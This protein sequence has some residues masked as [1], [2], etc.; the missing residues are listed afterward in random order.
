MLAPTGA[1]V[2]SVPAPA[3]LAAETPGGWG[4]PVTDA[5]R[6]RRHVLMARNTP[7]GCRSCP[8]PAPGL[9]AT[10]SRRASAIR[11]RAHR[12]EVLPNDAASLRS[13]NGLPVWRLA[14][15]AAT[16]ARSAS[17]T[18]RVTPAQLVCGHRL[19]RLEAA[20]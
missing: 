8:V 1:E 9:S 20:A 16:A 6:E 19:A 4:M 13:D 10:G 3:R 17:P 5:R 11:L 12:R 7:P 14:R 18:H 2:A 15:Y